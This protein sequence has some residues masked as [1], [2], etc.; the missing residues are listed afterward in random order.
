ME[1][2]GRMSRFIEAPKK[3]KAKELLTRPVLEVHK[4]VEIMQNLGLALNITPDYTGNIANADLN[5]QLAKKSDNLNQ[6]LPSDFLKVL[7]GLK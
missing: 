1:K 4:P 7:E 2:S 6:N 5:I 3:E